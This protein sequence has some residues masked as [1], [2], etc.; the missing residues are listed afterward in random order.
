MMREI[1]AYELDAISGGDT[2]IN[3]TVKVEG[4]KCPDNMAPYAKGISIGGG[5]ITGIDAGCKVVDVT[6]QPPTP[7]P[8]GSSSGNGEQSSSDSSSEKE[9]KTVNKDSGK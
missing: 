5:V 2:N 4:M 7:A 8:K 9:A 3:L 1:T 6:G